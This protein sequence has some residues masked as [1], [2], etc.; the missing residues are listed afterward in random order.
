MAAALVE[1]DEFDRIV[2]L[3]D[4]STGCFEKTQHLLDPNRVSFVRGSVSDST[5]VDELMRDSNHCI[6]LASAVGVQMIVNEP[7]ETLMKSVRGSNLVM[8]AAMVLV[9]ET[10]D[11]WPTTGSRS[12]DLRPVPGTLW[13]GIIL[14]MTPQPTTS[15]VLLVA[16]SRA[17]TQG[18]MAV[19]IRR[20]RIAR[21]RPENRPIMG[22]SRFERAPRA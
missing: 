6:H 15:K 16:D 21:V 8:H 17:A 22:G 2:I 9:G 18:G 11:R 3:D 19:S 4:L 12:L 20:Y 1:R 7:L 14:A 10:L 13:R 5:L